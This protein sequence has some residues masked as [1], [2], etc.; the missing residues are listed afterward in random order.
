MSIEGLKLPPDKIQV[1]KNYPRPRNIK[2]LRG[3]LG[4]INFYSKF[5]RNYAAEIAP[6]LTLLKK[7]SK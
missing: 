4:F 1:I 5:T 2:Q 6:L 3:F 7:G